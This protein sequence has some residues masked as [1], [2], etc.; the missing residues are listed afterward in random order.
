MRKLGVSFT[1][2]YKH[3]EVSV[4]FYPLKHLFLRENLGYC[5]VS[6]CVHAS[7][8]STMA[9][10]L[11]YGGDCGTTPSCCIM[12][13][14]SMRTQLSVALP[15]LMSH[16]SMYLTV[17]FLPVGGIPWNSPVCVPVK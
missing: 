14:M 5:A 11:Y 10:I 7:I 16:S 17:T 2:T 15:F 13:S 9:P 12:L 4:W 6:P 3:L 1:C 8:N